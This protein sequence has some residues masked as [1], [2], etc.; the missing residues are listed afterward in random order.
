MFVYTGDELPDAE[1]R[2][3]VQRTFNIRLDER[4]Q[5]VRLTRRAWVEAAR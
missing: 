4:L 2:A 3:R 1:L 5:F